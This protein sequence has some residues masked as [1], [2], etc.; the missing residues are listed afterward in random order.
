MTE[1][2]I[3]SNTWFEEYLAC[4]DKESRNRMKADK[5]MTLMKG[6]LEASS[7]GELI[8]IPKPPKGYR[9]DSEDNLVRL[10]DGKVCKISDV[11]R[12][13]LNAHC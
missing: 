4:P 10:Y 2:Q 7:K 3:T 1:E 13:S 5:L 11:I 9:W 6:F 8:V 12:E